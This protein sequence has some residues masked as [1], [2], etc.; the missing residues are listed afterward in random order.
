MGKRARPYGNYRKY[1]NQKTEVDG[2]VF[3]SK[4]E[5]KRYSELRIM[6]FAGAITELQCQK[7]FPC[8][9]NGHVVCTYKADFVYFDMERGVEVVEDVKS[10][11]TKT[12]LYKLKKKLV[13]AIY[14]VE[15]IEV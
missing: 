7:P 14:G 4:K 12:P 9:V 13:Q 8:K 3:D 10:E 11:P 2:I 5:A 6:Q 1:N 15:I